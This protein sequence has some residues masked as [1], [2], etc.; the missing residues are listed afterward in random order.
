[1]TIKS[2]FPVAS[3]D[4]RMIETLLK[5]AKGQTLKFKFPSIKAARAFQTR[6]HTLRSRMRAEQDARYDV[7]CRATTSLR[8][9]GGSY[10]VKGQSQEGPKELWVLPRDHQWDATFKSAGV[11]ATEGTS[12]SDDPLDQMEGPHSDE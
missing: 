2:R 3:F 8:N 5:A 9:E 11:E 7:I 6:L 10:F 12:I 4:P 1:M